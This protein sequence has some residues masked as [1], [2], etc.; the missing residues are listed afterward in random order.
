[1]QYILQNISIALYGKMKG[2]PWTVDHDLTIADELAPRSLL[3]PR[4]ALGA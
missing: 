4:D 1:L 2:I 3:L